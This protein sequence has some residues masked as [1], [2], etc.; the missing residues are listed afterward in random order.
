MLHVRP[1]NIVTSLHDLSHIPNAMVQFCSALVK[2]EHHRNT[3]KH[4][5]WQ[6][7]KRSQIFCSIKFQLS[8]FFEELANFTFAVFGWGGT[9]RCCAPFWTRYALERSVVLEIVRWT[10]LTLSAW[11]MPKSLNVAPCCSWHPSTSHDSWC[12]ESVCERIS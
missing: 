9:I 2:I 10:H 4:Q 8:I 3:N 12:S 7:S 11:T 6:K 5:A 1:S